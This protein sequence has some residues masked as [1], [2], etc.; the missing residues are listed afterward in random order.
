MLG[1]VALQHELNPHSTLE[2]AVF[3]IDNAFLHTHHLTAT[4]SFSALAILV[5]L[6]RIKQTFKQYWWIYR[7]PEVLLVVVISTGERRR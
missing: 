3:L 7:I 2:K 5:F 1:L 4:I 6:R